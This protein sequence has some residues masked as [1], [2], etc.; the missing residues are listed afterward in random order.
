MK[1][2]CFHILS[3]DHI[4]D[5]VII[6]ANPLQNYA[7]NCFT[8]LA[9]EIMQSHGKEKSTLIQYL[10]SSTFLNLTGQLKREKLYGL[11]QCTVV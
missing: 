8:L 1:R 6:K 9:E 7:I 10:C 11:L 3:I 2:V 5:P 4:D